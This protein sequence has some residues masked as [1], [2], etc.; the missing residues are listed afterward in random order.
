MI[1]D[2]KSHTPQKNE[3]FFLDANVWIFM[4]CPLGSSKKKDAANYSAFFEKI[5]QAKGQIYTSSGIMSE[6]INRYL[7]LDYY[8]NKKEYPDY[9]RNYRK[10]DCYIDTFNTVRE[11][12]NGKILKAAIRLNDGFEHLNI[13]NI[14]DRAKVTDFN[15]SL[16]SHMLKTSDI[17]VLTD[18]RDFYHLK[19]NHKIYTGNS[20]L[21]TQG[22]GV[23]I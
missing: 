6:F 12:V 8:L 9:K 14:M 3:K 19:S 17:A 16:F 4:Y 7:R 15:D 22:Q 21:L 13:E 11:V 10:S 1:I 18:D 2:I 5:I 23:E 20:K